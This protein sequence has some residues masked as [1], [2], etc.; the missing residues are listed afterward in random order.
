[1]GGCW[2]GRRVCACAALVCSLWI[3]SASGQSIALL[4][5]ALNEPV[6]APDGAWTVQTYSI[7]DGAK[8]LSAN[9]PPQVLAFSEGIHLVID[10]VWHKAEGAVAYTGDVEGQPGGTFAIYLRHGIMRGHVRVPERGVYDLLPNGSAEVILR[11][12]NPAAIVACA[13][14]VFGQENAAAGFEATKQDDTVDVVDLLVAYTPAARLAQGDTSGMLE[15]IVEAVDSANTAYRNSG[16]RHRVRLVGAMEVAYVESGDLLTDIEALTDSNDGLMDE[17][18]RERDAL[19]ADDVS[20]FVSGGRGGIGWQMRVVSQAFNTMAFNV[21]DQ[22]VAANFYVLAHE[23]GHNMGCS[24]ENAE[25]M[26]GAFGYSHA[27]TTPFFSTLMNART[28]ASTIQHFSNPFVFSDDIQTGEAVTLRN[29]AD[30]AQTLN[31]TAETVAAFRDAL[32][33]VAPYETMVSSEGGS[34]NFET[35][36]RGFPISTWEAAAAPGVDWVSFSFGNEGVGNDTLTVDVAPNG[37]NIGRAAEV[38]FRSTR[39][40]PFEYTVTVIQPRCDAPATP[41]AVAAA[42]GESS[43]GIRVA[44]STAEGAQEYR[45]FRA[46]D[47]AGA[48]MIPV[49]PWT[50]ALAFFDESATGAGGAFGCAAGSTGPFFYAVVARN[51]CGESEFSTFDEGSLAPAPAPATTTSL[52]PVL[53]L[54]G[55]AWAVARFR[56]SRRCE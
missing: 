14:P 33:E 10:T 43:E 13:G 46:R 11:A 51:G 4:G 23:I 40:E 36:Y 21:V 55:I 2:T 19:E 17:V 22:D 48:T 39:G 5:D 6:R 38:T 16:V 50:T 27:H 12:W 9:E 34:V 15:H 24:H 41:I 37:D 32:F 31:R 54:G 53:T 1:M 47:D 3:Q 56:K 42:D 30:N 52:V 18:H 49:S 20:L 26:A 45:V 35:I 44:W 28:G 25:G 8:S 7:G 29:A